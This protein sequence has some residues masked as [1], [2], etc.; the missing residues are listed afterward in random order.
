MLFILSYTYILIVTLSLVCFNS[1]LLTQTF[2]LDS[3][4]LRLVKL[5]SLTVFSAFMLYMF[6]YILIILRASVSSRGRDLRLFT[7]KE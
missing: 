7:L 3:H 2:L 6:K 1:A 5:R 4:L